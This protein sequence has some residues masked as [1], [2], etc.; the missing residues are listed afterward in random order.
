MNDQTKLATALVGGYMLGRT[1]Q[2]RRAVRLALWLG[3]GGW[4]VA[5]TLAKRTRIGMEGNSAV[6]ALLEQVRG[7]LLDAG[8]TALTSALEQRAG[9]LADSLHDRT[10]ALGLPGADRVSDVIDKGKDMLGKGEE[11]DEAEDRPAP[12][13]RATTT[14]KRQST[15]GG[16]RSRTESGTTKRGSGTRTRATSRRSAE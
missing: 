6:T 12:R 13:K 15:T 7:P 2:G 9:A 5:S 3:G 10:E 4:A 1:K 16:S 11:K 8:R 14:K